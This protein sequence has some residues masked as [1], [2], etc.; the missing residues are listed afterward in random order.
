MVDTM[1]GPQV[2]YIE[3]DID[4]PTMQSIAS[5]TNGAYFRAEDVN[6]LDAIYDQIDQL[7]RTEIKTRSYMEYNERFNLFVLPALALLLL[8]ILLLGT[9]FRRI[10]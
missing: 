2:E 3:A 9:R 4:E 8:E 7:E 1:F 6:A 10:P 5:M